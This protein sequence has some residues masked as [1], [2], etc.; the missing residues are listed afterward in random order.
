MKVEWCW[1][2]QCNVR[3]LE[4]HEWSIVMEAH[5]IRGNHSGD[6]EKGLLEALRMLDKMADRKGLKKPSRPSDDVP[7]I[8]RRLWHLIA[9][10]ELFTGILE[11]SPNPIWHHNLLSFGP[12]CTNCS[13]L[14]R[15]SKAN[16]CASCGAAVPPKDKRN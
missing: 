14:L 10:Y 3:M 11:D 9:G 15:T 12:K 7:V 4:D 2:C 1:R 5:R 13:R 8:S 6:Q 16:Y